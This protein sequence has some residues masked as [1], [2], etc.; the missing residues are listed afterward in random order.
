MALL[1]PNSKCWH[2]CALHQWVGEIGP[3]CVKWAFK[4]T[5]LGIY[6]TKLFFINKK[7]Q[8]NLQRSRVHPSK[9]DGRSDSSSG[10]L[11][12]IHRVVAHDGADAD[13]PVDQ[14][15]PAEGGSDSTRQRV[16]PTSVTAGK[17]YQ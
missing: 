2:R 4:T 3:K 1:A 16:E 12:E 15:L 8:R 7:R 6:K 17:R 13:L 10:F 9:S 5:V 14:R 11:H